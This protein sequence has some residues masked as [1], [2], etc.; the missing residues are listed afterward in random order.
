MM[1]LSEKDI[2]KNR[3]EWCNFEWYMMGRYILG[4]K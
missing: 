4:N 3:Y 1:L 2:L